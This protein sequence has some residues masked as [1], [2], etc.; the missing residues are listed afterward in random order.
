[1]KSRNSRYQER[2]INTNTKSNL[3]SSWSDLEGDLEGDLGGDLEG[4]ILKFIFEVAEVS[5]PLKSQKQHSVRIKLNVFFRNII[6]NYSLN[7]FDSMLDTSKI[8]PKII[9][10][11]TQ[12][13]SP[14][15]QHGLITCRPEI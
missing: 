8:T 5:P 4:H 15:S 7:I 10:K 6:I 13:G 9:P 12:L 2:L 11:M 1:M 14:V 3:E